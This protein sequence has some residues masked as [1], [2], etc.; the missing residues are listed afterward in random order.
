M[1]RV[2]IE[3]FIGQDKLKEEGRAVRIKQGNAA[4]LMW[5]EVR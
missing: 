2:K 1:K 3:D 5:P 4:A